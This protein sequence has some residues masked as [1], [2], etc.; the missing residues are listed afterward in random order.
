MTPQLTDDA[1]RVLEL[2]RREAEQRGHAQVAAPHVLLGLLADEGVVRQRLQA[3]GVDAGRLRTAAER[4]AREPAAD[5]PVGVLGWLQNLIATRKPPAVV[6]LAAEEARG[7]DHLYVGA[8]HLL[9]GLARTEGP[10][11]QVLAAVGLSLDQLRNAVR[12]LYAFPPGPA[13]AAIPPPR[14]QFVPQQPPKPPPPAAAWIEPASKEQVEESLFH[15]LS[16]LDQGR[17]QT[18]RPLL[19]DEAVLRAVHE[20]A[21]PDLV[22][23]LCRCVERSVC[24]LGLPCPEECRLAAP[25]WGVALAVYDCLVPW[26]PGTGDAVAAYV[27][28]LTETLPP[29]RSPAE[30]MA[31]HAL[32]HHAAE[33]LPHLPAAAIVALDGLINRS[34]LTAVLHLHRHTPPPLRA[35]AAEL[36]RGR[37]GFLRDPA[38]WSGADDWL[39]ALDPF[40]R[41]P[42]L[43]HRLLA[44][45]ET[46]TACR[47]LGLFLEA[48]RRRGRDREFLLAFYE[49]YDYFRGEAAEDDCG[50]AV[51]RWALL[52]RIDR[53]LRAGDG[54]AALEL[55]R[56]GNEYFLLFRPL[57]EMV[58]AEDKVPTDYKHLSAHL[59]GLLV[60]LMNLTTEPAPSAA[61]SGPVRFESQGG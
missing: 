49:S 22:E 4:L 54:R 58:I 12:E 7:L 38:P 30:V 6:E 51:R 3:L 21:H 26:P 5:Q 34:P 59:P 15:F 17:I 2:A 29:A 28:A 10:V 27:E 42:A 16:G 37:K 60:P 57:A 40:L 1:T 39:A 41:V 36:L 50:C 47:N 53:L 45:A 43:R 32:L 19:A 48:L 18:D 55:N 56:R 44:L 46:R 31:Y 24:G 52:E 13:K 20:R 8:E 9:L 25:I 61:V 11:R 33:A 23:A 35:L 14:V